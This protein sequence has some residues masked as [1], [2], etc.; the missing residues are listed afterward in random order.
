MVEEINCDYIY[1]N[2]VER[3]F[4]VFEIFLKIY[5]FLSFFKDFYFGFIFGII[6][7]FSE[8]FGI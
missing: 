8:K 5:R 7:D 4:F 1:D 6:S 2:D 3:R